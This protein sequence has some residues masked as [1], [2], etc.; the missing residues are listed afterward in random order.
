MNQ[1]ELN[2]LYKACDAHDKDYDVEIDNYYKLIKKAGGYAVDCDWKQH[3]E[4]IDE[5]IKVVKKCGCK[6]F[7]DPVYKGSDTYGWIIFP[8]TLDLSQE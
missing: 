8:P 4:A 1:K 7:D 5:L 6:V 2:A 3:S